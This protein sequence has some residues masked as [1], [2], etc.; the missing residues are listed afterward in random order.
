MQRLS[1]EINYRNIL[2]FLHNLFIY[3]ILIIFKTTA[4]HVD[5]VYFK[6]KLNTVFTIYF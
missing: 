5:Q 1:F 2:F 6:S 3:F 4:D